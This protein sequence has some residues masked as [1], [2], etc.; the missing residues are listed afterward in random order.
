MWLLYVIAHIKRKQFII[1]TD[2]KKQNQIKLLTTSEAKWVHFLSA[3][4]LKGA[5]ASFKYSLELL[6]DSVQTWRY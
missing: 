3:A 2:A 4:N 5:A 1:S 6:T